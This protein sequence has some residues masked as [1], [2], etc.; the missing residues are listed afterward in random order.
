MREYIPIIIRHT[1][2]IY[3]EN[4]AIMENLRPRE[5]LK[6]ASVNMPTIHPKKNN[7]WIAER[8]YYLSQ[9]NS[10]YRVAVKSLVMLHVSIFLHASVS[11]ADWPSHSKSGFMKTN[12]PIIELRVAKIQVKLIKQISKIWYLGFLLS[13]GICYCIFDRRESNSA[14]LIFILIYSLVNLQ[15]IIYLRTKCK[16]IN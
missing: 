15:I 10:H 6:E 12:D 4:A 1:P 2:I 16:M 11:V 13:L 3:R 5:S 14:S 9:Y 7:D 8:V